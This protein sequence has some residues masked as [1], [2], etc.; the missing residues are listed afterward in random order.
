MPGSPI[1]GRAACA[2]IQEQ[3]RRVITLGW[4]VAETL[5]ALGH[6]GE[7]DVTQ[8]SPPPRPLPGNLRRVVKTAQPA[9]A[10]AVG[11]S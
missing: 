10:T 6:H 1:T 8:V 7:C 5:V 11:A 9:R 2:E 3:K 4:G